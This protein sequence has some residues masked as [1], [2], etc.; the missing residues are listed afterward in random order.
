MTLRV[1]F[2]TA[3]RQE[4]VEASQWY[5]ARRR[6]LGGEFVAEVDHALSLAAEDPLRFPRMHDDIRCVRVR[7]FPYSLFFLAEP[8]RIVVLAVFHARRDPLVWQRRT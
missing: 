7:R 5:E 1:V 6:G 2:R 3:A 4:F 8:N